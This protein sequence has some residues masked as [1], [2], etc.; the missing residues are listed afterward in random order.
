[1]NLPKFLVADAVQDNLGKGDFK[2]KGC[3][4]HSLSEAV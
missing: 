2:I 3:D 1:M 4:D